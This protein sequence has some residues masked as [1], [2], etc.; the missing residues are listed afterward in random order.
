MNTLDTIHKL[1][2][3]LNFRQSHRV[4]V[5]VPEENLKHAVVPD[6]TRHFDL[7]CLLPDKAPLLGIVSR[8]AIIR[9]EIRKDGVRVPM[10]AAQRVGLARSSIRHSIQDRVA[11]FR[12]FQIRFELAS[13][14]DLPCLR[15][16]LS[17]RKHLLQLLVQPLHFLSQIGKPNGWIYQEIVAGRQLP[18]F[19]HSQ[20]GTALETACP[21][22][23]HHLQR[24]AD[25]CCFVHVAAFVPLE[26]FEHVLVFQKAVGEIVCK[27]LDSA[28]QRLRQKGKVGTHL[29]DAAANALTILTER[30]KRFHQARIHTQQVLDCV[31]LEQEL[32]KVALSVKLCQVFQPCFEE[33]DRV[34]DLQLSERAQCRNVPNFL[35]ANS[36]GVNWFLQSWN[37]RRDCRHPVGRI[38]A[39]H[40]ASIVRFVCSITF[41]ECQR[42]I[43]RIH[44]WRS[45]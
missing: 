45:E 12:I 3:A 36:P 13:C 41:I 6:F 29:N 7:T 31:S 16:D 32:C 11:M 5:P 22:P 33:T 24:K 35:Q 43:V 20:T 1:V 9:N 25:S 30:G 15:N 8:H 18:C 19:V 28:L 42:L 34:R 14:R 21:V 40:R 26:I 2:E 4:L 38:S 39:P 23:V 10:P 27:R 37:Q 44:Q 17:F